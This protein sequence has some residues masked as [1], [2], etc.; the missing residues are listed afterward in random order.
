[1]TTTLR[2]AAAALLATMAFDDDPDEHGEAGDPLRWCWSVGDGGK[3]H[4][5]AMRA[6]RAARAKVRP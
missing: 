1:M 6:L 3:E 2:E 5:L 4:G